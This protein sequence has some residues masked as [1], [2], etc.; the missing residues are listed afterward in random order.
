MNHPLSVRLTLVSILLVPLFPSSTRAADIL[1]DPSATNCRTRLLALIANE[2]IEI[3][4]AFWFMQDARYSNEIVKRWQS[5]VQVRVLVDP[6]ANAAYA[7]NASI[8]AQLASAGIPMRYRKAPG[9]LHWKTMIF[10]GQ[11]MV[12]FGAANYSADAFVPHVPYTDYVAETIYYTD[13][14]DVV[15]SFKR[16]FDDSWID[17][18]NFANYANISAPLARHYPKYSID[19]ELNFPPSDDY[20]S[21]ALASYNAETTR[22]DGIM[23]RITDRRHT[24][25]IISAHSRGVPVRLIVENKQYRDR[26]YLWDAWNVDRLYMAGVSLRWRGHAGLNHE[27]LVLL[28]GQAMTMFGSSNWTSASAHYQQEHNYFTRKHS[29]FLWFQ[30]QFNRMWNNTKAVETVK[31]TPLPPDKPVYK[32]PGNG[33]RTGSTS[34]T[35]KWY[36]GP[37]A[38]KYDVYLGTTYPPPRIAANLSLGPSATSTTYQKYTASL[39]AHTTYY[40]KIVAKTMANKTA[41]ASIWSFTTP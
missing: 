16:K 23:Y 2:Q 6:R 19:P 3:D 15:N 1:C 7:G 12:E 22:I 5:G 20:A 41:T 27:K 8:L 24:D 36:G 25:A 40:W 9:I 34:V 38:H 37:W 14:P 30:D 4:V 39:K 33:V 13:D 11:N 21:R 35:L 10:A 17:T 31:F 26:K 28:Y 32:S 29:I 18:S